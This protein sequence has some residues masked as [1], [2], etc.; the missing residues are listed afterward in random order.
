MTAHEELREKSPYEA[1]EQLDGTELANG[2]IKVHEDLCVLNVYYF[3]LKLIM[4]I[5]CRELPRL[6]R[7][8]RRSKRRKRRRNLTT[9]PTVGLCD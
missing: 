5:G 7:M 4:S 9:T 3:V 6:R 1:L 2:P 8:R